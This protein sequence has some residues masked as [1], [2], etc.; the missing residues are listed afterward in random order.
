MAAFSPLDISGLQLWL[1]GSN[2]SS[3]YQDA[4]RTTP[5]TTDADVV[6]AMSDL[7]GNGRH[8]TQSTTASKPTYRAAVQNGRGVVRFDGVDDYLRSA[9]GLGISGSDAC[10][11]F[12]VA[13]CLST[14]SSAAYSGI[15]HGDAAGTNGGIRRFSIEPYVSSTYATGARFNDGNRLFATG[16]SASAFRL[17][18]LTAGAWAQYIQH[19]LWV[20]GAAATQASTVN[21]TFVPNVVDSFVQIGAN[22]VASALIDYAHAD[23]AEILIF[24][25]VLSTTNRQAVESYL[26]NKWTMW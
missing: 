13:K 6:G 23:I 12:L 2:L 25:V 3:L 20:N 10:T 7:S 21:P 1:D 16:F 15:Y 9:G 24:N 26:N 11:M 22:I 8:A 5:V 18:V 14:P 17:G 4:A 19:D